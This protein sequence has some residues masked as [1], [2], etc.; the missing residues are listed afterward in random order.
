MSSIQCL[1]STK[2][3]IGC[4]SLASST[5][6]STVNRHEMTE[7]TVG[8][9]SAIPAT[10]MDANVSAIGTTLKIAA[11]LATETGI[12][13]PTKC[14]LETRVALASTCTFGIAHAIMKFWWTLTPHPYYL[15]GDI[16][17]YIILNISQKKTQ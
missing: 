7:W 5:E 8:E 13:N 11:V 15:L 4:T 1:A 6:S 3:T 9:S 12:G 14:F 10:G 17:G 2:S 16:W